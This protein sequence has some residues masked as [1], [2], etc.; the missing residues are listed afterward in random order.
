VHAEEAKARWGDTPAYAEAARRTKR[1]SKDDWAK[2]RAEADAIEAALA[3]AL[4]S[5]V[6]PTDGAA[7]ALAERHRVHIEQWF[8]PCPPAMHAGLGQMYV[9][10]PR[11]AEHYE[12]RCAG[13]A[14]F[15][16][17]AIRANAGKA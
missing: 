8:Y 7:R 13:L 4:T 9:S 15:V 10:D 1:Y 11:F 6:A 3:A 14:Q 2:I 16:C 5:G 17:D 12:E